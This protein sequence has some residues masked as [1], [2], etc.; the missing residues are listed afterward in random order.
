MTTS[1]KLVDIHQKARQQ[2]DQIQTVMWEE[3][4]QCITDR[5]FYSISGAMWE[6]PLG[7]QF[8]NK[9][10]IEI[11]KVHLSVIRIINEYRN[12][13]IDVEFIPKNGKIGDKL[14]ETCNDLYR[15]SED[16]SSAEEAHDN[17]FEEAVGGGFGAFRLRAEYEDEYD[18]EN[19][20]QVI[21]IEPIY[22]ADMSVFWDLDAKKYDKSDAKY[23]FVLTS[24]TQDA[25]T[26]KYG[27]NPASWPS[28]ISETTYFDW[29]TP[30][31]V[32]IAEYFV[33]ELVNENVH[34]YQGLD[35]K[36]EK[37]TDADFDLNP[38]LEN[39][40]YAIGSSFVRTRKIKRPRV[41]KYIMSGAE[42]LEDCGYLP[43]RYIPIVPVYGKR[44]YVDNIERCMG[45]VRLSKD[46][47]RLK[48]M[49]TSKL[50]EISALSSI[51]KPIFT[52]E[53][54][55]GH[56]VS[57]SQDNIVNNPYLLINQTADSQ[58]NALPP[59]PVGFTKPPAI[60]PAMAALLAITDID[61]KEILG[62]QEAGEKIETQLSG[63]AIEMIQ[64]RLDMQTFIYMSNMAKSI[65]R[66]GE[67]WLSMA[68]DIFI[69]EG[70]EMKAMGKSREVSS[71]ALKRPIL[72]EK[73]GETIYENDLSKASFDV[74]VIVGPSS[75]SKRI[76][77]VNSLVG[78]MGM[79]DDPE[80]KQILASMALM[81]MEGEGIQDIRDYFRRKM[82]KLGVV[83]P[84]PDEEAELAQELQNQPPDPNAE[85][86]KAA[87][88]EAQGKAA[89]AR[90][91]T[92][93]T[94]TK[95]EETQASTEEKRVNSIKALSE[96]G[97]SGDRHVIESA[98]IVGALS[99][100]ASAPTVSATRGIPQSAPNIQPANA[101]ITSD[102]GL[103]PE[104]QGVQ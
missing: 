4:L 28:E 70:R 41:H 6:G 13:R 39:E 81:N 92:I 83:K 11:N 77:T 18:D 91:N 95:V 71:V 74:S 84:T 22:D 64:K 9:P 12:N 5:R 42:V 49:Q 59:G 57:W 75:A 19:E 15:A 20:K 76:A 35:G 10:R 36:E 14:S 47:Q 104:N 54:M 69:E 17:A 7:Q 37:Y 27:D 80:T 79:T 93:L 90:A 48:N 86:L 26:E 73:T 103:T 45:H 82:I 101:E 23:C 34:F 40:L 30:D 8:E 65:K 38:E 98:R 100:E 97:M 102:Q 24:M 63:K 68:Q 96:I 78:M 25:Y 31:V 72:D 51:E 60:P 99:Q 3:R 62:S 44:W 88:E 21:C 50:A 1:Q 46:P 87:A 32:Y 67:I 94:M 89:Q 33:V 52:P 58:G 43:G 16:N 66:S 2:M 61:M 29:N 85:Y 55:A 53:Q 56:E